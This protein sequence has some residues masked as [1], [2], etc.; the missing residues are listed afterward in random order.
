MSDPDLQQAFAGLRAAQRERTPSFA[1]MRTR[2]LARAKT[3]APAWNA[4]LSWRLTG[5]TAAVVAVLVCAVVLTWRLS[6]PKRQADLARHSSAKQV[7]QL[8]A[9]I[10]THLT[11]RLAVSDWESPTDFLLTQNNQNT[12][13]IISP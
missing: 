6:S 8:V 7:E 1:A 12:E 13:N 3:D 9:A 5:L 4:T 10:D 2:A 11:A